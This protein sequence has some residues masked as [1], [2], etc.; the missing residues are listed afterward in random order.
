MFM[1]FFKRRKMR[2]I[3]YAEMT[4]VF[5]T[6]HSNGGMT[7]QY[8]IIFFE[9]DNG[10]REYTVK[11]SLSC[12]FDRTPYFSQCETWVHTGLLPEWAK[13]PLAEKLMR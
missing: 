13:D 6:S 7:G 11:G 8:S 3:R 5:S 12:Y 2:V 1:N 4:V 9:N 10:K